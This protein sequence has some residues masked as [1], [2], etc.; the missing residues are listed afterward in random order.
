MHVIRPKNLINAPKEV[1]AKEVSV[2]AVAL[3]EGDEVID[4][5]V[6][7]VDKTL[8]S[9]R[10]EGGHHCDELFLVGGGE[11]ARGC[12]VN[13]RRGRVRKSIKGVWPERLGSGHV[14]WDD[15]CAV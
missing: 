5:D 4:V 2:C 8:G 9:L 6:Y 3:G 14:G 15:V 1:A 10:R 7:V 13:R 12:I 11:D